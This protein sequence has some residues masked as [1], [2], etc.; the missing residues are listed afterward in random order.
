MNAEADLKAL[1][2]A[3]HTDE[4]IRQ[5]HDLLAE[6][7]QAAARWHYLLG[8]AHRKAGRWAQ[9]LNH[10]AEAQALD[11]DSPAAAAERMLQDILEFYHK[12]SYNP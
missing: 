10:Y 11:P 4:A 9:A 12:D 8:N 2:T 7:P 1:L 3:G 5:L 6:A